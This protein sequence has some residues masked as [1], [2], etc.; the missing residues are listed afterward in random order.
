[1]T[2]D[3]LSKL[4]QYLLSQ[5]DYIAVRKIADNLRVSTKT[6]Y[7]ELES[8]ERIE[9]VVL[10][11]KQGY[12]VKL[13]RVK[14]DEKVIKTTIDDIE[15][16]GTRRRDIILDLLK[17]SNQPTTIQKLSEKYFVSHTSIVNDLKY[18]KRWLKEYDV[19]LISNTSGTSISSS[20]Q[21]IRNAYNAALISMNQDFAYVATYAQ[22]RID[23]YNLSV[24]SNEFG[25]KKV[26]F[27]EVVLRESE[28][29][30]GFEI[31]DPYY[32]NLL[33]H[34]LI[35]IERLRNGNPIL[36]VC[37]NQNE[38]RTHFMNVASQISE[39]ISKEFHLHI[40]DNEILY[41]YQ[42]L[43]S[44]GGGNVGPSE[45]QQLRENTTVSLCNDLIDQ[46]Q[47]K[48]KR[49]FSIDAE[50][51]AYLLV[52]L[53]AYINRQKYNIDIHCQLKSVIQNEYHEVYNN[54]YELL[55][56]LL[57][58]WYPKYTL[59]VD[60]ACFIALYFQTSM[61][62]KN[63]EKFRVLVVCSS[64]VGTSQMVVTRLKKQ[65]R[66]LEV[67]DHIAAS[68]LTHEMIISLNIDFI[69]TTVHIDRG[70]VE[71]PVVPISVLVNQLDVQHVQAQIDQM[72]YSKRIGEYHNL[73]T[74]GNRA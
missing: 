50:L 24:L 21:N 14:Q 5:T 3:R 68:Y 27:V 66:N 46:M 32:I 43:D 30:L 73:S 16:S 74:K 62:K 61:E 40:P 55:N 18:V 41:I 60:E 1:M 69:I 64:G 63:Q 45:Y 31:V 44:L 17:N 54:V 11:R 15:N 56:K 23:D 33:T 12:G 47:E 51:K 72:I 22:S 58:K 65:V 67:I 35:M 36:N 13:L 57:R 6:V 25:S 29:F 71:I 7:R 59:T 52:H 39:S 26:S 48:M 10:D 9:G 8:I 42:H 49:D 2:S 19:L 37:V 53:H 38:V 34:I 4:L 20:E 70:K 28:D